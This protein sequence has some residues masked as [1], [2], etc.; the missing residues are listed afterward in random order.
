MSKLLILMV[1]MIID[2][3]GMD[4]LLWNSFIFPKYQKQII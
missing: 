4:V 2:L 3:K 1:E